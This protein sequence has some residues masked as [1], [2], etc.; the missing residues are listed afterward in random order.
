MTLAI[1]IFA[2]V[3]ADMRATVMEIHKDYAIV[4]TGDGR[5][6]RQDTPAGTY[7]IGDEITIESTYEYR[8]KRSWIRGVVAAA[9]VVV[10]LV[11]GSVLLVRYFR[12]YGTSTGAVMVAQE[13]MVEKAVEEKAARE[14]I[15]D[16]EE[17]VLAAEAAPVE[18]REEPALAQMD[19]A[20]ANI[21]F[22]NIYPLEEGRAFEEIIRELVFSFNI[23]GDGQLQTRLENIG[24]AYIF[25]GKVDLTMLYADGTRARM[26][27][28]EIS[29]FGPGKAREETFKLEPKEVEV[30][31]TVTENH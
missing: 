25:S 15:A 4:A 13:D 11:T 2:G 1:W 29:G 9:A 6:L 3:M 30:I 18:G 20:A 5:F 23:T 26:I 21:M 24:T 31:L 10:V 16:A 17:E 19:E 7:E 28:M 8:P 22:E 12:E 27:T 14:E